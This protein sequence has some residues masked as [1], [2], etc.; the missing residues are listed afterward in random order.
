MKKLTILTIVI[1][2]LA[3]TT[4]AMSDVVVTSGYVQYGVTLGPNSNSGD[5]MT[6]EEKQEARITVTGTPDDNN[7]ATLTLKLDDD[8]QV[9][10][11]V[12]KY[13][14]NLLSAFGLGDI[15]VAV[16]LT[17]GFFEVG[18]ADVGKFSG[19]E[20]ED[21]IN[22]KN[23][24][25]QFQID[26]SILDMVTIR[27][28]IDPA[29]VYQTKGALTLD[30]TTGE[31]T[32]TDGTA[33]SDNANIGYVIG[34]FGGVD[35][36]QAEIFYTNTTA[37]SYYYLN[38][39]SGEFESADMGKGLDDEPGS[40]GM[41]VGVNLA[42]GDIGL[43]IGV[44]AN[45]PL[46]EG[47]DPIAEL[48]FG[49]KFTFGTLLSAGIGTYGYIGDVIDSSVVNIMGINVD[50]TPIEEMLTI[51]AGMKIG[52]DGD[53]Y[54]DAFRLLDVGVKTK[55]GALDLAAGY[56]YRPD[57]SSDDDPGKEDLYAYKTNSAE[58]GFFIQGKLAF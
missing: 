47:A 32:W 34:A 27:V 57:S 15:P 56:Q 4:P 42:F 45:L 5:N 39:V 58:G 10:V 13:E 22:T 46:W 41:G 20:C 35:L 19:Y 49:I 21:V 48:G 16:K 55:A 51:F 26:T 40:L 23:K 43:H 6:S 36:V 44:N 29:F 52:L 2:L 3:L 54:D 7:T 9:A 11:D 30:A 12:A 17:G 24:S 8:A 53:V 1:V 18:N 28:G 14:C 50:V 38:G 33:D 37:L 25:W 31:Y